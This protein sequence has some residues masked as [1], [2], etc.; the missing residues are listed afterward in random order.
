MVKN[1]ESIKFNWDGN[2]SHKEYDKLKD[3]AKGVDKKELKKM[4]LE[5]LKTLKTKL[6]AEVNKYKKRSNVSEG[7]KRYVEWLAIKAEKNIELEIANKNKKEATKKVVITTKK[8]IQKLNTEITEI[9]KTTNTTKNHENSETQPLSAQQAETKVNEN[10]EKQLNQK[11]DLF[12]SCWDQTM[13]LQFNNE[14]EKKEANNLLMKMEK[15]AGNDKYAVYAVLTFLKKYKENIKTPTDIYTEA[16]K[17]LNGNQMV[18]EEWDSASKALLDAA[19]NKK[20]NIIELDKGSAFANALLNT[21]TLNLADVDTASI[22]KETID[23]WHEWRKLTSKDLYYGWHKIVTQDNINEGAGTVDP[24]DAADAESVKEQ[25]PLKHFTKEKLAQKLA[26][27]MESILEDLNDW[28]IK[29]ED[30]KNKKDSV[31]DLISKYLSSKSINLQSIWAINLN[32]SF[33]QD[34]AIKEWLLS[35]EKNGKSQIDKLTSDKIWIEITKDG[36]LHFDPK[37]LEG[38]SMVKVKLDWVDNENKDKE[39]LMPVSHTTYESL[40][41]PV[42]QYQNLSESLWKMWPIVLKDWTIVSFTKEWIYVVWDKIAGG[43][44]TVK[45][46]IQRHEVL[47]ASIVTSIV[48]YV[49]TMSSLGKIKLPNINLSWLVK[50]LKNLGVKFKEGVEN[51]WKN[52][53]SFIN[54]LKNSDINSFLGWVGVWYGL[55]SIALNMKIEELETKY[56]QLLADDKISYS[57]KD[58]VDYVIGT[59]LELPSDSSLEYA[60]AQNDFAHKVL[61]N[62]KLLAPGEATAINFRTRKEEN[63]KY[64]LDALPSD[65]AK[66]I[67]DGQELYIPKDSNLQI[68]LEKGNNEFVIKNITWIVKVDVTGKD[69]YIKFTWDEATYYIAHTFGSDEKKGSTDIKDK[70]FKEIYKSI[71]PE[72]DKKTEK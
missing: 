36:F 64:V 59:D 38:K 46:F 3:L 52:I 66:I 50:S 35:K 40:G 5:E 17:G 34:S 41:I 28:K 19:I 15:L 58:D 69:N 13:V 39:I 16:A 6:E 12:I 61:L 51:V 29:V 56:A 7:S 43:A 67:I 49:L 45:D 27:K 18:L 14:Q 9:P 54:G 48:T 32:P 70:T 30:L 33:I 44:D 47:T 20:F 42:S 72:W 55:T 1:R 62:T 4:K 57:L 63:N 26:D 71:K 11:K 22:D 23:N 68:T 37:Q 65:D 8:K 21:L 10:I 31:Y 25:E 2:L 24:I 60:D 53:K